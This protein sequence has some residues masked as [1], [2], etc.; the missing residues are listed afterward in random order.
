MSGK[1]RRDSGLP[2]GQR[3]EWI[4][5][6][7]TLLVFV[8]ASTA[9]VFAAPVPPVAIVDLMVLYT[10]RAR[11]G[12]GGREL[13]TRQ[14]QFAVVEAN[15]VFQNSGVNARL[16]LVH[17][18]EI[19]YEESGSYSND[20]A[21]L[22]NAFDGFLDEVPAWRNEHQADLVCLVTETG[23][24]SGFAGLPG[25]SAANAFSVISRSRLTGGWYLP[26]A[27]SSNFGCQ[28]ERQ[29]ADDVGAFHF[30]YGYTFTLT[31]KEFGT[32]ESLFGQRLPFFSN[33]AILF[34]GHR[35]GIPEGQPEAANNA[36]VLNLTAPIVAAFRDPAP[37]TRPPSVQLVTPLAGAILSDRTNITLL[38]SG[39][40]PDCC[41]MRV[42]F[43]A[44]SEWLGCTTNQPFK[45][46]WAPPCGGTHE[47]RAVATDND[48]VM[49]ASAPRT[50]RVRP[51]NDFFTQRRR[52]TGSN[53]VVRTSN[54][55]ASRERGEPT[56]LGGSGHSLWWTWTAPFA[57]TLEIRVTTPD[58]REMQLG[59]YG[60]ERLIDLDR[61]E[62]A[63]DIGQGR[64]H[65]VSAGQTFQIAVDSASYEIRHGNFEL[66]LALFP[67]P[68]NDSFATPQVIRGAN[69]AV[70]APVW[71]A[72]V[73]AGEERYPI[74]GY[75]ESLWYSWTP[76]TS[77]LAAVSCEYSQQV[78]VFTG[79]ALSNLTQVPDRYPIP[80]RWFEVSE[81]TNYFIRVSGDGE[82][83]LRVLLSTVSI[84]S[85]TN[86]A[87]LVAGTE[88]RITATT[89]AADGEVSRMEFYANGNL[90]TV[91]SNAPFDHRW[92]N[93][94]AGWYS[95]KAVAIDGSGQRRESP[96]AVML[97]VPAND[98][99]ANRIEFSGTDI[100]SPACG[101][102][103][104]ESGEPVPP[105]ASGQGSTWW[106]WTAPV[107]GRATLALQS[108]WFSLFGRTVAVFSGTQLGSLQ[109]V[110]SGISTVV[111]PVTSGA[112]YQIA[113]YRSG[114]N[115]R[116]VPPYPGVDSEC[117]DLSLVLSTVSLDLPPTSDQL[118]GT[119]LFLNVTTTPVDGIIRRVEFF[120][121]GA[122]LGMVTNAPYSIVWSNLPAGDYALVGKAIDDHGVVR[123]S[124]PVDLHVTPPNDAF[125]ASTVLAGEEV[126]FSG[127]TANATIEVNE[128]TPWGTSGDSSIWYAWMVSETALYVIG[129]APGCS[130]GA[131]AYE[132]PVLSLLNR[133]AVKETCEAASRPF[134]ATAGTLYH[135]QVRSWALGRGFDLCL[136]PAP[137]NDA[138]AQRSVIAGT[139]TLVLGHNLGATV[140]PA[141][142]IGTCYSSG[143]VWW[144][145]TAPATGLLTLR[146]HGGSS[147]SRLAVF[148]GISLPTL[149]SVTPKWSRSEQT[150]AF[151]VTSGVT[152]HIV[153]CGQWTANGTIEFALSFTNRA[154]NNDFADRQILTGTNLNVTG[155]TTL[156]SSE[157]GEPVHLGAIERRSVWYSWTAPSAGLVT[158]EATPADVPVIQAYQGT[159]LARVVA[160]PALA[161]QNGYLQFKA[162]AGQAYQI[163]VDGIA[164]PFDLR[165]TCR[166]RPS[167]DDFPDR[168]VLAGLPAA[169]MGSNQGATVEAGEPSY[170]SWSGT[171]TV[172]YSWTAPATGLVTVRSSEVRTIGVFR[173]TALANLDWTASAYGSAARFNAVVGLTYHIRVDTVNPK[174]NEFTLSLDI[175]KASLLFPLPGA[176]FPEGRSLRLAARVVHFGGAV[177]TVDFLAGTNRLGTATNAPWSFLW[178]AVS[179]GQYPLTVRATDEHGN[180]TISDPVVI[181][182]KPAND[183]FARAIRLEGT[184]L[185]VLATNW[186]ATTES[187]EAVD[188]YH[189]GRTLW[190]AW[191]A[192]RD[193]RLMIDTA[194]SSMVPVGYYDLLAPIPANLSSS[195][196]VAALSAF[197]TGIA[198]IGIPP[199]LTNQHLALV[200]VSTG[201]TL[202]NLTLI[203]QNIARRIPTIRPDD[204]VNRFAVPVL[205]GLTYR[206]CLDSLNGRAGVGSMNLHF[207]AAPRPANDQFADRTV[208]VGS[209][210]QVNGTML[211]ATREPNEP[212]HGLGPTSRTLWWSWIAP[213]N[214]TA[215]V[216]A[217]YGRT[218][219]VYTGSSLPGLR[220]VARGQNEVAFHAAVGTT[221]Q[222]VLAGPVDHDDLFSLSLTAPPP[223]VRLSRSE[224][225]RRADGR[226]AFRIR[227]ATGQ[228]FVVQASTN[229]LDWETIA[230]ETVLGGEAEVVDDSAAWLPWR[231]YRTKPLEAAGAA[232]SNW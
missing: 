226:F 14:I 215:C 88:A 135:I 161:R 156:A 133:V 181:R 143:S 58:Y 86:G 47:L 145:W 34:G 159:N 109:T 8:L 56:D 62:N 153:A 171:R 33:P 202:T 29:Y 74:Y 27:L 224:W 17:A 122:R 100:R 213:A 225:V 61:V 188:S 113:V 192:P 204:P 78:K 51:A 117:L 218:L 11:D 149:Q 196:E 12:A 193:G 200:M 198:I 163:A 66:R 184:N 139:E 157:P 2:G 180:V 48:G 148:T 189:N 99:F 59:V 227:G 211:A 199:P 102:G 39:S 165:L 179:A 15:T 43:Y 206:L 220:L 124:S 82:G 152:Y 185:T 13:I 134:L 126:C 72:S 167:N 118:A 212:S 162:K 23:N 214:G 216:R 57:G 24:F 178:S 52:L 92:T 158:I 76:P 60:G 94:S 69:V 46:S 22:R 95:L 119:N 183:D 31:N 37:V 89:T 4:Q 111:C 83:L 154:P 3:R 1:T 150:K 101:A 26:V 151:Q 130:V 114:A 77:G 164:G 104:V 40:D 229:L 80:F 21:R 142:S 155:D 45:L 166:R 137:T 210:N 115:W 223:P 70:A 174:Q 147:G 191:T 49:T 201:N 10:P 50:I 7:V 87:S 79:N 35:L 103:T 28:R 141:E 55:F 25:P 75:D 18:G 205:A 53:I 68:T 41:V 208:L 67:P 54:Q 19:A 123:E 186:G 175:L 106:T 65:K 190:W 128:P 168:T 172:W 132:G 169:V 232:H 170:E 195:I 64:R 187:K 173:G 209:S 32:V 36:Q 20:L 176:T 73:E 144:S 42:D 81:R 136:R 138:F 105:T 71:L 96:E 108:R 93:L 121:N 194:G 85:P 160:V 203:G 63:Q 129:S 125:S 127:S 112:T 98:A 107:S 30:A 182:I 221:Y 90:L 146:G 38:A 91:L 217:N 44:G 9:A 131:V 177:R 140:E 6:F 97:V 207:E 84:V 228:S 116:V 5:R 16:R 222:I 231:F 110:A 197:T 219:A 230:I 120:A